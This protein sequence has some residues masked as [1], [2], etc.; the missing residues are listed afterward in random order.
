MTGP[1]IVDAWWLDAAVEPGAGAGLDQAQACRRLALDGPNVFSAT[2][3]RP[4]WL[5]FLTRLRNPLV[6][7]L[8]GASLLSGITGD[9]IGAVIIGA[10]VLLSVS[11]DFVQELRA[12]RVAE[13]LR[14]SVALRARVVRG[15]RPADIPVTDVVEGD[16]VL[17]AAGDLVPADAL[18]LEAEDCFMQESLLTGEPFPVEKHAAPAPAGASIAEAVTAVFAGTS[19]ISGSARAL[20]CR[21]GRRTAIGA[22]A[23]SLTRD[24]PPTAFEIGTRRFGVLIMRMTLLLVAGVLLLNLLADKPWPDAF[25]FAVALAVGLTP[26]LL[27]MVVSVTLATGAQRMAQR[28]VVVRRLSAIENLG[29]MDV[30]CTDKTGTLTEA[31]IHLERHVGPDGSESARVLEVAWLN[32]WFETG[33]RSPMDEAILAHEEV[34]PGA[35]SKV[36]EVPFDFER[37]RVSVLLDDGSQ[38]MLAVKGAAEEILGLS[39]RVEMSPGQ[40]RAMDEDDRARLSG[41]HDALAD[42]GFRVLG[43]ACKAVP[44]DHPHARV[45]DETGL[46]FVGYAAFLDPPKSSA[47]AALAAL[48]GL[49]VKVKIV[50]GDNAR[51]TRHVCNSLGIAVEGV[52][53]GAEVASM[54]GD[55]LREAA[56][57]ATLFC[58]VD[59]GQK[60]RVIEALKGGGSVVGYLG[61]G[62]NDAPSLHAADVGISVDSAADIA[63]ESSDMILLRQDL[64]VLRDGVAEG[65]RTFGNVMKYIMMGTSSNFGNMLS[66]ALASVVLPFLPMLPTQVLLNNMLYDLSEIAI[67][68]DRVDERDLAAPRRWDMRFIRDFMWVLGPVSSLFDLLTFWVLLR[69]FEAGEALFRTCWFVESLA[70]QVLVILVI[71]TRGSPLRSRPAPV[72]AAVSLAVVAAA[73]ALPMTPAGALF[74]FVQPPPAFFAAL[75][76]MTCA[77]LLLVEAVKRRFYRWHPAGPEGREVDAARATP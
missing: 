38:R 75:A 7:V 71:R 52:L 40:S 8:L 63:R 53:T 6:L 10:M 1:P 22:V 30:L 68:A 43:I 55:A 66:M 46:V 57:R 62:V 35:W 12:G 58:R 51:V 42:E 73:V 61:D 76:A 28:G 16:V 13:R 44:G 3:R 72:L 29:S 9:A 31:R 2:A 19:V 37:R 21:T 5:Q 67:P 49:G 18:L 50:T 70:T 69:W 25:L 54:D 17:L 74:G 23:R 39:N 64:A 60:R 32:S 27:P 14:G 36:D 4:P 24:P 56:A 34:G 26:E 15:G 33:L 65:R 77:Y 45:D 59:P 47:A 11:I 20:V 41:L 48:A